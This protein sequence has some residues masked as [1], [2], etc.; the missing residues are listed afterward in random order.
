MAFLE[1]YKHIC[2]V[3]CEVMGVTIMTTFT[4]STLHTKRK[5]RANSVDPDDMAYMSRFIW[6]YTFCLLNLL[7]LN[8]KYAGFIFFHDFHN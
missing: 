5:V 7:F 4:R 1:I 2:K 6:I 8:L 3:L